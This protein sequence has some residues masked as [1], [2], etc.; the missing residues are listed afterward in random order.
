MDPLVTDVAEWLLN[1]RMIENKNRKVEAYI[2]IS[3]VKGFGKLIKNQLSLLKEEEINL[4]IKYI[5]PE[6][7]TKVGI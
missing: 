3:I 5:I 1:I 4:K 2:S 7:T 6:Y